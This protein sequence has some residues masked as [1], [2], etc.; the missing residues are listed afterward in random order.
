MAPNLAQASAASLPST[1]WRL[2][3]LRAAMHGA[4]KKIK[5]LAAEYDG[6]VLDEIVLKYQ[7][8]LLGVAILHG[9]LDAG[10]NEL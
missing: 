6:S 4:V 2:L 5:H 1:R 7:T 8:P 9:Q 3:V 10:R